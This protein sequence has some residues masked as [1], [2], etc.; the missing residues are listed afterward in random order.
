M[1]T[2]STTPTVLLLGKGGMLFRAWAECLRARG[3]SFSAPGLDDFDFRR[4]AV[5]EAVLGKG[6]KLVINCA[7]YTEVDRAEEEADLAR[8]VN[9]E[10]PGMLAA[11]C[12]ERDIFFVHYSTDYVF[13][14]SAV[15]P[16]PPDFPRAPLGVYGRSKARGEELIQEAQSNGM[17]SAL[18]NGPTVGAAKNGVAKAL[19][20]RT[21]WLYAP[22]GKNFV[23]TIARLVAT[24][25]EVRVVD[26]QRGR[27]TSATHLVRISS[28][29]IERRLG[30]IFH[31]TDGGECSWFDFATA[32]AE[33]LGAACQVKPCTS[34]EYPR[35]APR[36]A[37]SV[38]DL[39][40]TE[41]IVGPMPS[42]Q[43]NLA[44]V[45]S[46]ISTEN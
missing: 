8:T 43:T 39:A 27:P 3:V 4:P 25:A 20:I 14:G 15:E 24:R 44:A 37:Y 42:W 19:I 38:L 29:L 6:I 41:A 45:L 22:W 21:S 7:G 40:A 46:C 36:P 5:F 31:V 2:P 23:T 30:G 16:Y 1:L 28:Q 11:L 12:R 10:G 17:V 33:T 35:P 32:I 9:A 26:D 13:D 18:A 34:N